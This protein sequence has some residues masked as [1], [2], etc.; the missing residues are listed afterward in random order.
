MKKFIQYIVV[1]LVI[2]SP[3]CALA[4]DED[5]SETNDQAETGGVKTETEYQ[6]LIDSYK[7]HLL[8]VPKRVREEIKTFRIEIAKIQK[9]KRTLYKSLSVEA[10]EYLKLEE[11]FRQKLPVINGK[12][13][14]NK[15]NDVSADQTNK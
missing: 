9:Q 14:L 4:D 8:T 1:S 13:D 10:Q 5:P 7:Q 3:F 11:Q 12:I 15:Q 2:L 6:Q